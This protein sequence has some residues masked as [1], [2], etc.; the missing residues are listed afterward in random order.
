VIATWTDPPVA[1]GGLPRARSSLPAASRFADAA[2]AERRY[3]R[4]R[5][6]RQ[7][8]TLLNESPPYLTRLR[9]V[10]E[11]LPTEP[12][13][14]FTL[15]FVRALDLHFRS[16]VTFF[17]G[18]NG[19]GKSTLLEA[20]AV[21]NRLPVSGGARSDLG[22]THGPESDSK[23]SD[24]LRPAFVRRAPDGYFLR[25][26]FHAHFASLLDDRSVDPWFR[27][28]GDPYDHY[29][30]PRCTRDLTARRFYPLSKTVLSGASSF[31]TSP[32]QL[33]LRNV[34][35]HYLS[36]CP[37]LSPG[38]RPSSSSPPIRQS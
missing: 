21:L 7:A 38:T 19:S 28:T 10:P 1:R 15:P 18:E 26:E 33:C 12:R 5:Q 2:A 6:K 20:I 37:N 31:S 11:R 16:P 29:G 32:S 24:V 30:A 35:S 3:V 25:A 23:L 36:A 22:A 8:V 13:F 27:M 14:P 9:V 34:N 17:V 4:R